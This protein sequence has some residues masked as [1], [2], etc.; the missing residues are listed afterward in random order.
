MNYFNFVCLDKCWFYL[1]FWKTFLKS[2]IFKLFS[3]SQGSL[4]TFEIAPLLLHT[5]FVREVFIDI[6][7]LFV[8]LHKCTLFSDYVED[9][10]FIGSWIHLV[11]M[12]SFLKLV[13]RLHWASWHCILKSIH[14]HW[15]CSSITFY[16][17]LLSLFFFS[18]IL[19]F[20]KNVK[21]FSSVLLVFCAIHYG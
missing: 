5:S 10:P 1:H 19:F 13:L 9:F 12:V 15:K 4:K 2:Q 16:K 7:R 3:L 18:Y 8:T 21:Q 11:L 17:C 14:E 20:K 6:I